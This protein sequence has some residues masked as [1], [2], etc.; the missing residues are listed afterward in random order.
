MLEVKFEDIQAKKLS[1]EHKQ[2]IKKGMT[3]YWDKHRKERVQK[4]GYVTVCI[5]N[6]KYYKHRLVMEEYLGRKLER[7]EQ[8][9]H[10]NGN[11]LD[12]NIENLEL[13][14]LGEHQKKHA[15]ENKLGS[16]RKGIEP[17]NKTPKNKRLEIK[18]LKQQGLL[19]KDICKTIKLSYATVHKYLKEVS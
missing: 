5:G 17:T 14:I 13:Q 15:I 10:K 2:N 6:K 12:N 8:V 16:K 18:R 9:H 4:N 19:I 1:L 11:K 3:K 7:N